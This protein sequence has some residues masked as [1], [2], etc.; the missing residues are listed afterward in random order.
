MQLINIIC[1]NKSDFLSG[2]IDVETTLD[3]CELLNNI[4][5]IYLVLLNKRKLFPVVVTETVYC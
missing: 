3:Q 5:L 1:E 2:L 4:S